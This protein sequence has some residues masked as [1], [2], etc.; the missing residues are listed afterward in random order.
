MTFPAILA[1][2]TQYLMENP[3]YNIQWVILK[4]LVNC[5]LPD[6]GILGTKYTAVS[7]SLFRVMNGMVVDNKCVRQ[8]NVPWFEI[9]HHA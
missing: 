2:S 5:L 4:Y 3:S 7:Y 8:D 6:A 1:T 9:M